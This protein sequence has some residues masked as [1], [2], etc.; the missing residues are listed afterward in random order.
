MCRTN[1]YS[2][3]DD[4]I[5]NVEIEI[6][7]DSLPQETIDTIR[8]GL[9]RLAGARIGRNGN[10]EFVV[11]EDAGLRQSRLTYTI[12]Q[13]CVNGNLETVRQM[14]SENMELT[15]V[16]DD[17]SD[18]LLHAGVLSDNETLLRYLTN[19][20]SI[21]V[22]AHNANRSTPLHYAVFTGSV[23]TTTLLLNCGAF[24]DAQDAS[25]K[26]PLMIACQRNDNE[27]AQLLVDRGASLRCFDLCGDSALHHAARGR[28]LSC[29][30]LLL[31]HT[32]ADTNYCNNFEETPLHT[33]CATGSHT[34][35]RFLLEAG[36]DPGLKTKFGKASGDYIAQDNTRLRRLIANHTS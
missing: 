13:A 25:G 19:E 32:D 16:Q 35:V 23:R 4:D 36:A 6:S 22:N 18:T 28:C 30:R 26:T 33:A 21:P 31:R 20:L 14:V 2:S 17:D 29:I 27:V 3:D 24:V 12:L 15:N 10:E 34:A 11:T 5:G 7:A 9:S 1:M 8:R